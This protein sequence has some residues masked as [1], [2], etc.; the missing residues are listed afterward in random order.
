MRTVTDCSGIS[1]VQYKTLYNSL[2][3]H[4]LLKEMHFRDRRSDKASVQHQSEM[5]TLI[6]IIVRLQDSITSH[7][8]PKIKDRSMLIVK[9]EKKVQTEFSWTNSD[10]IPLKFPFV[11]IY[12]CAISKIV[13]WFTQYKDTILITINALCFSPMFLH[14]YSST[15][16]KWNLQ[17]RSCVK[18]KVLR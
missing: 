14:K 11:A 7:R 16:G 18:E 1:T 12:L 2:I 5:Q 13:I 3:K 9:K 17:C 10:L 4:K 6:W 8:Q 15:Q